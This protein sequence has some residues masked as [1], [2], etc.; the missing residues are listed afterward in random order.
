MTRSGEA[1]PERNPA[2]Q[3]RLIENR[4]AA[5]DRRATSIEP[6]HRP[7]HRPWLL[8]GAIDEPFLGEDS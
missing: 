4:V 5:S 2:L 8:P 3:E 6:G 7:P 1:G